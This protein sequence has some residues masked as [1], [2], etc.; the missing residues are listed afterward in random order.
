M[1]DGFEDLDVF[2]PLTPLRLGGWDVVLVGVD[3]AGSVRSSAGVRIEA[4]E[5]TAPDVLV[6]PG[7]G[8]L[9]R[10]EQGAWT[11]AHRPETQDLLR[12]SASSGV[13]L[14][15][16]CTGALLLAVA[17]LLDGRPAVTNASALDDLAGYGAGVVADARVVDDGDRVTAGGLT[18]GL[19]LGIWFVERY[20]GRERA[21]AVA[22]SMEYVPQGRVAVVRRLEQAGGGS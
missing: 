6:V 19:D 3:G 17:G 21:E 7:G 5:L 1:F 8:W 18:A 16:V 4:A 2:G 14:A 15:S 12:A 10:A 11:Q 13:V 9:D 22:R 20:S